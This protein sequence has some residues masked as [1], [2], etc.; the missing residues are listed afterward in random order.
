MG[1]KNSSHY[2]RAIVL[3]AKYPKLD[4]RLMAL[5]QRMFDLDPDNR[6]NATELLKD[7]IFSGMAHTRGSTGNMRGS[8]STLRMEPLIMQKVGSQFSSIILGG[9]GG[10][11]GA[12]RFY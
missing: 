1:K 12:M 3:A 10:R 7:P 6:P 9:G 2:T 11:C 8:I 5:V 4:S